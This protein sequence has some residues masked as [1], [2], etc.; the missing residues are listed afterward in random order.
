MCY[1]EK[2]RWLWPLTSD[3]W[4][5]TVRAIDQT[6]CRL[7]TQQILWWRVHISQT[8]SV[9][10]ILNARS[11]RLERYNILLLMMAL[12]LCPSPG[13]GLSFFDYEH[14][15]LIYQANSAFH[16]SGVDKWGPASA[17]KEK[18]DVVHSV[19][20]RTRGVHEKPWNLFAIPERLQV[21]PRQCAVQIHVYLTLPYHR[22]SVRRRYY[23]VQGHSRSL[24]VTNF[25]TNRKPVH[26]T[27]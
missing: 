11:K 23:A 4:P 19:S 13:L 21:C 7:A 17:G 14:E 16:P 10:S 6:P 12:R 22:H 15:Q 26:N 3:L 25:D 20:G 18:A 1:G 2:W 8:R 24:K 27:S 9:R 5:L